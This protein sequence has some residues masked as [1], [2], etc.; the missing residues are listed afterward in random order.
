MLFATNLEETLMHPHAACLYSLVSSHTLAP[1]KQRRERSRTNTRTYTRGHALYFAS[2]VLNY[3]IF[4]YSS[5]PF[6]SDLVTGPSVPLYF[7][8]F[9]LSHCSHLDRYFFLNGAK[10]VG[11]SRTYHCPHAKKTFSLRSLIS[12]FVVTY[13]FRFCFQF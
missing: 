12:L 1:W 2:C 11:N 8:I 5:C 10:R 9:P 13:K 7:L 4:V 6:L 3:R